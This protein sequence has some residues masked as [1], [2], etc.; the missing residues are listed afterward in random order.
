MKT[1]KLNNPYV[2]PIQENTLTNYGGMTLRDYFAAKAMEVILKHKIER[3]NL[4][5][6]FAEFCVTELA[7]D[8]ADA[9]LKQRE[10]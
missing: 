7:Y 2:H 9:M 4:A 1:E 3:G 10:L 5:I 6:G 8:T